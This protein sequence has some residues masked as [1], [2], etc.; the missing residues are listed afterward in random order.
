MIEV[1]LVD[2]HKMIREGICA[3]L[4][5]EDDISVVGLAAN[6][7]EAL[8]LASKMKSIIMVMDV[9]MPE[10]NGIDATSQLMRDAPDCKV[11]GLSM[12]TDK[13]F[14]NG[15]LK[16]GARGFLLKECAYQEL[17]Q[18]VRAVESGQ[19]YLSPKVTGTV[20]EEYVQH[21][22][23]SDEQQSGVES[24]TLKEREALQLIAEGFSTRQ[25]A[26][27]LFVSVKTIESRRRNLQEK[28]AANSVADLTKIAIREGLT[29]L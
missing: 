12:Y 19:I 4:N 20:V 11:L 9:S 10:M 24:L 6:G 29:T 16:A 27:K 18:A 15:M 21:L 26:D 23:E 2:D 3:L 25:I 14:V 8:R 13:R 22:S 17:V 7:R 5:K 28:L 1:V